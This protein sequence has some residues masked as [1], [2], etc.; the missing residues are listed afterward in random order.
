VVLP[1]HDVLDQPANSA[2]R[3][4]AEPIISVV[5]SPGLVAKPTM[6]AANEAL[7]LIGSQTD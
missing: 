1:R 2:E 5:I 4:D 6:T 7:R 3:P